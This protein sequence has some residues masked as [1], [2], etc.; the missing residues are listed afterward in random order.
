M[1]I[2][3]GKCGEDKW[4]ANSRHLHKRKKYVRLQIKPL[5]SGQ[6]IHTPTVLSNDNRQG[7]ASVL[8]PPPEMFK[9][10]SAPP[11]TAWCRLARWD[12]WT[13]IPQ[14]ESLS[15]PSQNK[16]LATPLRD[17]IATYIHWPQLLSHISASISILPSFAGLVFFPSAFC[18]LLLVARL[19]LLQEKRDKKQKYLTSLCYLS[20]Y[21]RQY[22]VIWQQLFS[23]F[24]QK[25][26]YLESTFKNF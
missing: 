14:T 24:L 25:M 17:D 8:S 6:H 18:I 10:N 1:L 19:L 20:Y 4:S 26:A 22:Y 16:I 11:R 13:T 7:G 21:F 2:N 15:Q 3:G 5:T 12:C 9:E 23:F